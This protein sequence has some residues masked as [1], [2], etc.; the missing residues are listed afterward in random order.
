LSGS[1][2]NDSREDITGHS[3]GPD[4]KF[5]HAASQ[6]DLLEVCIDLLS[7]AKNRIM[8]FVSVPESDLHKISPLIVTHN[9]AREIL[10]AADRGVQISI[11][12]PASYN[13]NKNSFVFASHPN[14]IVRSITVEIK[15]ETAIELVIV[16]RHSSLVLESRL[17]PQNHDTGGMVS[18]LRSDSRSY[19]IP[20]VTMFDGIWGQAELHERLSEV[21]SLKDEYIR[22]QEE[23]YEKLRETERLKDEFINIA[24]HELRTPLMPI[25]G[26]V[27]ILESKLNGKSRINENEIRDELAVINRNAERLLKLAEDILEVSRMES[28]M[29]KMKVE[30]VN[31]Y[32]L[33]SDIISDIEKKYSTLHDPGKAG[34]IDKTTEGQDLRSLILY[35][36]GEKNNPANNKFKIHF[37]RENDSESS[38]SGAGGIDKIFVECDRGKIGQVLFNLLDNAMKFIEGRG[39]I[40]VSAKVSGQTV[41]VKV[42]DTG[43]G[44]DPSIK[45]TLFDKFVS[46]SDKGSGLGLYISKKIIEAHGGKIWAENTPQ[47]GAVFTFSLPLQFTGRVQ[48]ERQHVPTVTD[49]YRSS[50]EKTWG[51]SLEKLE[52]MKR[53]LLA[54]R[55]EALRKRNE[56]LL[57]YQKKVEESRKLIMAKQEFINQ[58]INYKK[59]RREIDSRIEKGLEGLQRLIEGLRDN[60]LGDEAVEKIVLHPTVSEAIKYEANKVTK[61]EFFKSIQQQLGILQKNESSGRTSEQEDEKK[62]RRA[63]LHI[64]SGKN[65]RGG[66]QNDHK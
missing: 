40:E 64:E 53:N 8:W 65:H 63:G 7:R 35:V 5:I 30:Q 59:M 55:D 57:Q 50:L 45:D 34:R 15:S 11:L 4:S 16:D 9:V 14:V 25:M 13:H 48:P 23:L 62:L 27:E 28:G 39:K 56:G 42:T 44:I 21:D 36:V 2:L 32:S 26:G 19:T 31:L 60:I 41:T 12:L 17:E 49:M 33:I 10:T 43:K 18:F 37:Q 58:Q 38:G 20:Y 1:S 29:F 61:T 66:N 22:K 6:S 47:G 54:A 52:A 51:E 46:K 3:P 24:A